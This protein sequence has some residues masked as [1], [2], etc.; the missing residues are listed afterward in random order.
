MG[1]SGTD[2]GGMA[3]AEM[4]WPAAAATATGLRDMAICAVVQRAAGSRRMEWRA[5]SRKG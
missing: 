4:D 5:I 2:V 1:E 3:D